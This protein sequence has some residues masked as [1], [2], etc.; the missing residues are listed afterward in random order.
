V[1]SALKLAGG[2]T[3]AKVVSWPKNTQMGTSVGWNAYPI[4][5]TSQNKEAAWAFLK[6]LASKQAVTNLALTGQ[7]TPGRTSVFHDVLP[8]AAPEAGLDELWT[9]V[10]YA[11]PTPSPAASDA[12]NN[13][14]IKTMTQIYGS[15]DDPGPLMQALHTQVSSFLASALSPS[16]AHV[17]IA[18]PL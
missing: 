15:S 3:K 10:D 4:M 6:Y 7:A 16:A 8:K 5:K 12:I 18:D 11:T 2:A 14:I 1:R 17:P 13:A 9:S